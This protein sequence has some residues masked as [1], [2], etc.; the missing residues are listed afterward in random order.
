MRSTYKRLLAVLG[1]VGL[2]ALPAAPAFAEDP[3]T[4]DPVTKIVDTAGVLG[5]RDEAIAH[6]LGNLWCGGP[7][8]AARV[9][10]AR[11]GTGV[12]VAMGTIDANDLT[13]LVR[14]LHHLGGRVHGR[15]HRQVDDAVGMGTCLLGVG[16]QVVPGE[17]RQASGHLAQC[18]ASWICG[19]SASIS[20]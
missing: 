19:G 1:V 9:L 20:G 13:E 6:D 2:L 3:V 14:T 18:W 16:R 4:L 15:A 11:Q 8:D 7:T 5:D 12:V 10:A 17:V